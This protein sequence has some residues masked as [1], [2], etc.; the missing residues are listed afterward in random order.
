ME[1]CKS[2]LISAIVIILFLQ[3]ESFLSLVRTKTK[4]NTP[5]TRRRPAKEFHLATTHFDFIFSLKQPPTPN[6]EDEEVK[7]VKENSTLV[8]QIQSNPSASPPK[9]LPS[10]T[11]LMS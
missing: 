2:A 9:P 4:Q 5:L 6:T 10:S 7:K 1:M 8:G 3:V 11:S